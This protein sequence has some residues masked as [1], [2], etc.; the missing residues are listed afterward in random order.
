MRVTFAVALASVIVGC[1]GSD[2]PPP[3]TP[4]NTTTASATPTGAGGGVRTLAAAPDSLKTDKV[5]GSDGAL[6]P[7]GSPDFALNVDLDGPVSAIFLLGVDAKGEPT[8]DYQADTIT[9]LDQLP[10]DFPIAVR[11]GML[12]AGI[13]VW[14]GD[15]MLS[16]NDGSIEPLGP[17][18]HKL[19]LYVASTGVLKP[20]ESHVRI[21]VSRPDK[22]VVKG[23]FTKL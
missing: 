13:G 17:G 19:T 16:K 14:E 15:K 1:G 2:Q 4:A 6:K 5:G 21:Y 12:T 20:G 3:Q 10:K 8:G 18:P 9:G 11:A 23:P 7:D 22:S